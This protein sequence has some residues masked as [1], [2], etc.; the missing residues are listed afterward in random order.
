MD[1]LYLSREVGIWGR[2]GGWILRQWCRMSDPRPRVRHLL[3]KVRLRLLVRVPQSP[4]D[5]GGGVMRIYRLD[6]RHGPFSFSVV[7][8]V[9]AS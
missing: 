4:D 9:D 6:P 2:L 5:G 8:R 7:D 1:R 3:A